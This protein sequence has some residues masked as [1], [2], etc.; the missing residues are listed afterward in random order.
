MSPELVGLIGIAVLLVL[1]FCRVWIG[2]AMAVVGLVGYAYLAGW[3]MAFAVAGMEPLSQVSSYTLACIPAF[4]LMGAVVANAGVAGDLYNTT[5]KWLGQLRGGLAMATTISTAAFSAVCGS[6]IA[7]TV[8]MGKVAIPEMKKYNYDPKLATGA[9]A[10]GGTMGILIPPSV[11]LIL[12]GLLTE[13]S[14]GALFMAGI[15]PG[16]LEALFYVGTIFILCRFNRQMGPPGPWTGWREKILSLKNTSPML[17]LFMLVIGGIYVGIFTPTEAGGIGAFGAIVITM[18]TRRLNR[19][20]ILRSI[21]ET[22]ESTAMIIFMI[23]GAFIFM[24]FITVSNLSFSLGALVTGL[25]LSK[26]GVLIAIIIIYIFLGC[27]L[28]VL[29]LILITI[30]IFFP[31]VSALGFNPIWFGIIV[32]RMGEI[33]L[34][35]PPIGMNLFVMRSVTDEPIGTI[36]RGVIP[37]VISDFFHVALLVAFPAL[38]LFLPGMM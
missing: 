30:P 15:I 34:I 21:L 5:Y 33:G 28:D 37:F 1:V 20:N 4:L 25:G 23:V 13:Q 6:S 24:R 35:T 17:A 9:V 27:F 31:I 26:Y 11:G 22:V 10:A 12:Y 14:I 7:T 16:A 38:A 2:A 19:R 36:Y 32:T 29:S 8:A 18:A 3:E